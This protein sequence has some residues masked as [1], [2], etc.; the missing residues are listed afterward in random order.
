M[1]AMKKIVFLGM[2]I[3]VFSFINQDFCLAMTKLHELKN[4]YEI[5]Q[6]FRT[7]RQRINRLK[8]LKTQINGELKRQNLFLLLSK[9]NSSFLVELNVFLGFI[10]IYGQRF[11]GRYHQIMGRYKN[12]RIIKTQLNS[13]ILDGV[14]RGKIS[15]IPPLERKYRTTLRSEFYEE[16]D[17]YNSE[18]DSESTI[19]ETDEESELFEENFENQFEEEIAL[20][21]FENAETQTPIDA[22]FVEAATQTLIEATLIDAAT[23]TNE[24]ERGAFTSF[25]KTEFL[26]HLDESEKRMLILLQAQDEHFKQQFSKLARGFVEQEKMLSSLHSLILKQTAEESRTEEA[27]ECRTEEVEDNPSNESTGYLERLLVKF[28]NSFIV[29]FFKTLGKYWPSII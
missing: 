14:L 27:K 17:G 21:R 15:E 22:T 9:D 23:Q 25:L 13:N 8:I 1:F 20:S 18:D 7:T 3:V 28:E 24:E 2:L 11:P 10:K 19:S 26:K 12:Q 29:N 4:M 5:L 16:G 6:G